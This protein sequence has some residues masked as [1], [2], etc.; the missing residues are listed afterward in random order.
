MRTTVGALEA[1]YN[2]RCASC[3]GRISVG[4]F[5]RMTDDGVEH[6]DCGAVLERP[7][8]PPCEKCWLVHPEGACDR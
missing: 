8:P 6:L 2:G 5:I 1:R 3:G 4:E 7:E